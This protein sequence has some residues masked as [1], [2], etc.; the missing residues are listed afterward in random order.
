MNGSKTDLRFTDSVICTHLA[1]CF[2]SLWLL[3]FK[4]EWL[5]EMQKDKLLEDLVTHALRR[6]SVKKTKRAEDLQKSLNR[7]RDQKKCE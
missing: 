2:F 4:K 1:A 7:L 6:T 3:H 5:Q